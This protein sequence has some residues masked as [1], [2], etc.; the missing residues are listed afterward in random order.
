M[1]A[2]KIK[3]MKDNKS[4]GIDGIPTFVKDIVEQFSTPLVKVFNLS[5]EEGIVTS[6]WKEVN[7]T[8]L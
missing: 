8:P 5:L 6:E 4:Y 1:I 2:N 3:K 7:T